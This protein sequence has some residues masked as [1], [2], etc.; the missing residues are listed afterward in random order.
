MIRKAEIKDYDKIMHLWYK[1]N[2]IA[3]NFI[4][5]EYWERNYQI[6]RNQILP[7][8]QTFVFVDKHQIKGFISVCDCNYVGACFVD[9]KF[10]NK[11]IGQKLVRYVQRRY[12]QLQLHV[13]SLNEDAIRFYHKQGFKIINQEMNKNTAQIQLLM[14]WALGCP[15]NRMRKLLGDS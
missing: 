1:T 6:V 12:T 3:H 11:R 5:S 15:Q 14:C 9:G 13:Y 10:Q 4:N 7:Q 2:C 8:A